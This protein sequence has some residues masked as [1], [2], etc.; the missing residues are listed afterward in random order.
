[1]HQK[2]RTGPGVNSDEA[3]SEAVKI[4]KGFCPILPLENLKELT[5]LQRNLAIDT[6]FMAFLSKTIAKI[7]KSC[8]KSLNL[9]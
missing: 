3:W 7:I 4:I 9:E 1:M 6:F 8:Q 5:V 2:D